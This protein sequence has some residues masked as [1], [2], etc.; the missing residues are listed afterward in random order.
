MTIKNKPLVSVIIPTF[1]SAKSIARCIGSVFLN[2]I[3]DF[4][5]LIYDDGSDDETLSIIKNL[6]SNNKS[7][8]VYNA[9]ENKGAGYAR[10]FLLNQVKGKYIAFLD[11]DDFWYPNKL[12][13]QIEILEKTGAD[14]VTCSYDII[15]EE[16]SLIGERKPVRIINFFTMHFSN[17]LPTSMTIISANLVG[18]KNMPNLRKRQ[19]YAYWLKLFEENKIKCVVMREKLGAYTRGSNT[20]SSSQFDNLRSNFRMFKVHLQ[21][22]YFVTFICLICNILV[23]LS[24]K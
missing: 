14:I 4:E 23:R 17:W 13:K 24:R 16:S 5:V 3:Q 10:G 11:S 15:D 12:D 21:Y 22:G 20:L 1:N 18:V 6:Y 8:K 9:T 7:V 2:D 19:D